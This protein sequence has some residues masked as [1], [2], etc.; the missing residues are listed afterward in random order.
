MNWKNT[1]VVEFN[2]PESQ[3]AVEESDA[4]KTGK[5]DL[6]L[7]AVWDWPAILGQDCDL[8]YLPIWLNT[9]RYG[10]DK[11]NRR[12]GGLILAA[13]NTERKFGLIQ[14]K[15]VYRRVGRATLEHKFNIFGMMVDT[16]GKKVAFLEAHHHG[17]HEK[18]NKTIF[19]V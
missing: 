17:P 1:I 3:P 16:T 11:N 19:L 2:A 4:G 6:E 8:F 14:W 7:D 5:F 9:T 10:P 18:K 12:A 13:S 15:D